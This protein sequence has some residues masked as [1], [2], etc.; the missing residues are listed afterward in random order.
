[1][2][3]EKGSISITTENIFP[4]IKKWLYSEKDIFI[5]ELISNSSD[6]ITK[7]K[8]LSTIG[9]AEI[10]GDTKF[11]IRVKVNTQNKSLQITDNGVGMTE[12]EVKKYIN[13][14]AFSGVQDFFEKYKNMSDAANIIGH[15]GLGFYSTF[16]A[17]SRVQIDTLS[18]QPGATAVRWTSDTGMEYEIEESDKVEFGTTVTVFLSDDSAEYTDEAKVKEVLQKYFAFLPYEI[19]VES[20][21]IKDNSED[22]ESVEEDA[23]PI[24]DINPLWI[25][26]PKECTDEEYK[27]FYKKV[28]HDF[29]DPLFWI[30]LNMDYPFNLKGILYFPKLKTELEVIEGQIK[31]YYNQVFVAN[32]IKEV[33]PEFL[34]LLKGTIDCPDLPLNVSRSFLQSDSH[35]GRISSHITKK[36]ADKLVSVFET[37]RESYNKYWEDISLFVKFGCIKD[38]KFFEKMKDILVFKT[39][40][41]EYLTLSDYLERN[42]EKH[43]NKVFYVT[44]ETQQAQYV[45]MFKDNRMEAVILSTM[46][47]NHFTTFLESK[48]NGVKFMR[49]DSDISESMK[50]QEDDG[51]SLTEEAVKALEELFKKCI[52][53]KALDVKTEN[54]KS[55]SV[56]GVILLPEDTRRLQEMSKMFKM[57][58]ENMNQWFKGGRTLVLNTK[59]DLI[60]SLAKLSNEGKDEELKDICEH[61]YDLALMSHQQLGPEA[62]TRFIERSNE[63]LLKAI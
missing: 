18:Y 31:L 25:K 5:R 38:E 62:M 61:I 47:D 19:Y 26:N 3:H 54:L 52:P 57:G 12:D 60:K 28:F 20:D 22:D 4:I 17:A 2:N 30:H 6:A 13:Q 63:I 49:I 10:S 16:M 33:I 7:L 55:V 58:P 40:S 23:G 29:N 24:N 11:L 44:D 8:K 56:P 59:N 14:I 27:T 43:E 53:D 42:K 34:M 41:G 9:E 1:M 36:V 45:K 21:I 32:N 50:D 39:T 46:I 37:D 35:V 48:Y 15:F 51:Q